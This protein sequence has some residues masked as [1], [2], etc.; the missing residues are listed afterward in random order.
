MLFPTGQAQ[1]LVVPLSVASEQAALKKQLMEISQELNKDGTGKG[2]GIKEIIKKIEE[3]EDEIIQNNITLSS[4]ERQQEIKIKMLELDKA[5]KEQEEDEKRESKES[6]ED[7][8]KNNSDL[9]EEYL[10]L[11]RGEVEMLK[12]IPT[13]LKPYYKNK[14][15]EYIKFIE[16]N[17]D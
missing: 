8:K 4:I 12:T 7:Y 14:V 16:K 2:N 13:N 1:E 11:K 17:Y 6:L 5:S 9:F 3:V 10:Q 15:N